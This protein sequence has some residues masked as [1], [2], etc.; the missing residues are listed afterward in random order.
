M[1]LKNAP[2]SV[3]DRRPPA[4]CS[5]A[6][7]SCDPQVVPSGA[8]ARDAVEELAD[9]RQ[10]AILFFGKHH[11]RGVLEHDKLRVRQPPGHV[12]RRADR[13][14]PVV[15][16]GQHQYGMRHLAQPVLDVDPSVVLRRKVADDIRRVP[17][18][19]SGP[20]Q[21]LLQRRAP[22]F[23]EV[24]WHLVL[25]QRAYLVLGLDLSLPRPR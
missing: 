1:L 23:S 5:A 6:G 24:E 16:A 7:I 13:A 4:G 3:H 19:P 14:R 11:V 21:V 8:S 10:E 22:R 15:A 20:A 9:G 25:D 2:P 12:L 18:K 17:G